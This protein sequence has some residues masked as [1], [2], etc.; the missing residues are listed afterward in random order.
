MRRIYEKYR[1]NMLRVAV[2]LS[3]QTT[4][5]EDV[6]HDVFVSFID[7]TRQFGLTG[8]LKA[9]LATCVAHRARNVHRYQVRQ[10]RLIQ[11]CEQPAGENAIRPDRWLVCSE[12][13][14]QVVAALARLPGE[15]REALTLRLQAGMK[16][17]EIA[18][19]QGVPLKTALSRYRR[20]LS[21]M[22]SLLNGEV[23]TC[24]R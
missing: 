19:C 6:V 3:G 7:Q 14:E 23:P 9:Y 20:G 18:R 12:E 2:S 13:L 15:Q 1:E 16:F 22:R 4:V 17:K 8:S 21:R 10:Q 24:D 11:G 5:A